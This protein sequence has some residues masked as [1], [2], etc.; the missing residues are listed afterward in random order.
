MGRK[1]RKEDWVE[2]EDPT[3]Q[4]ANL[5]G[6]T[7]SSVAEMAQQNWPTLSPNGQVFIHPLKSVIVCGT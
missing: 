5:T 2:V 7:G 1:G 3:I 6:T 4:L